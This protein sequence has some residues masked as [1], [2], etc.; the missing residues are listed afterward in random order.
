MQLLCRRF[1]EICIK[2]NVTVVCDCTFDIES[3]RKIYLLRYYRERANGIF[4]IYK[5]EHLCM[6][7]IKAMRV[8]YG[9]TYLDVVV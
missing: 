7:I 9:M 3:V 6:G 4:Y 1:R 2:L 8:K 5:M